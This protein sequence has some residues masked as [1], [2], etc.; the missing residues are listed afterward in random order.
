MFLSI[1]PKSKPGLQVFRS[2]CQGVEEANSSSCLWQREDTG[3]STAAK[4]GQTCRESWL[5][6]EQRLQ[7]G[8]CLGTWRWSLKTWTVTDGLLDAQYGQV[9][10]FN[11]RVIQSTVLWESPSG[12]PAGVHRKHS[13]TI[14]SDFHSSDGGKEP[15]WNPP[16]H[17]SS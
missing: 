13:R 15:F 3:Q 1:E 17:Y 12:A 14:L 8:N 9:W 10:V 5:T 6:R 11:S 16:E 7:V 2:G 4:N